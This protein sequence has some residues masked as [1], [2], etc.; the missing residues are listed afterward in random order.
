MTVRNY[1]SALSFKQA[2][3]HRIR[4]RSADGGELARTRQL[5]VFDR[6][7]ARVVAVLGDAVV[8]KG[9]LVL[10]LRLE[11]ARTTRDIDLP[12]LSG[13]RLLTKTTTTNRRSASKSRDKV[14][15]GILQKPHLAGYGSSKYPAK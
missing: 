2:L 4:N 6:Y 7:L 8:L 14:S 5:L 13:W 1:P 12:C 11:R 9:G 15:V 3:E 10:E